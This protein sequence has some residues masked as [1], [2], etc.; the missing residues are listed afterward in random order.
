MNGSSATYDVVIDGTPQPGHSSEEAVAALVRR[1]GLAE[2]TVTDLL[3][4]GR[5]V[6]KKDLDQAKSE[7]Y[8]AELRGCGVVARAEPAP[9]ASQPSSV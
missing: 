6:V 1:F 3:R 4:G 8:I 2:E 5:E 7:T 9:S